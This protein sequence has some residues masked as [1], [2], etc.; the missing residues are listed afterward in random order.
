VIII[1]TNL[2][3]EV[4]LMSDYKISVLLCVHNGED[5]LYFNLAMTSIINQ[6]R[7]A[8]QIV[9][10]VDGQVR[11]ELDYVISNY[12]GRLDELKIVRLPFN[13][14]LAKALNK[15]LA[16]CAGDL[17]ARMD[18]DDICMSNRF[19]IQEKEFLI[20]SQLDIAGSNAKLI[21]KDGEVYGSKCAPTLHSDIYA[22]MFACPFI[23]PSVMY[24]RKS[25]TDI[26]GYSEKLTRRQDYEL[27]FRCARA[28]YQ[29]MNVNSF[30][31]QYRLTKNTHKK[32]TKSMLLLQGRIG[33]G[34]VCLLNQEHWKKVAVFYPFL[35]SFLPTSVIHVIYKYSKF[36]DPRF[37]K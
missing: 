13:I 4:F 20:N 1:K 10:V 35:R 5:L 26:G 24:K 22:N 18:S 28:G 14:G 36:I 2:L 15:G 7:R 17:I 37:N 25:I 21:D 9:L 6:T 8:D 16:F 23:H 12:E 27:W 33:F 32:Q 19:E 34:G 30:L 29:F 3:E 11:D 31:I